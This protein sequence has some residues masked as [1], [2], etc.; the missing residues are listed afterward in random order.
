MLIC[1][2][3]AHGD[4]HLAKLH[5]ELITGRNDYKSKDQAWNLWGLVR[6][7]SNDKQAMFP[8]VF[9]VFGACFQGPFGLI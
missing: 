8:G 3:Q 4:A 6:F 2:L 7:S 1:C 5:Q 9:F